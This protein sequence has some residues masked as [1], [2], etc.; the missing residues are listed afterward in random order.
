MI[1]KMSLKLKTKALHI[2]TGGLEIIP[3]KNGSILDINRNKRAWNLSLDS[4][5]TIIPFIGFR[6]KKEANILY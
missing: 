4:L 1:Q 2:T 6:A 5:L 3:I